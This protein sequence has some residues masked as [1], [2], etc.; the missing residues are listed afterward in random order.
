MAHNS[1]E[2]ITPKVFVSYSWTSDEHVEWVLDLAQR[3]VGNGVDVVIDRWDLKAGQDKFQ[4]MERMVLD[5]TIAKV[6]VVC[7]KG[8]AE[9]ANNRAGGVGTESTII[10][11]NVYN[12]VEQTKFL[13]IIAER[14]EEKNAF[15]PVFLESRIYF[16]LSDPR[17]FSESYEELLRNLFGKPIHVKPPLGQPPAFLREGARASSALTYKRELFQEAIMK[18]KPHVVGLATDF[19]EAFEGELETFRLEERDPDAAFDEQVFQNIKRFL[20]LRD[21]FI[22]FVLFINRY[23]SDARL[24]DELRDFF[25]RCTR[26]LGL[27]RYEQRSEDNYRFLLWE[28]FLYTV[29]GLVKDHR[30]SEAGAL[31]SAPYSDPE[32]QDSGTR[33]MINGYGV[34]AREVRSL[35]EDRQRRLQTRFY[36]PLAEILRERATHP[37]ISFA[38]LRDV[39]YALFLR[40]WLK[41]GDRG[42]LLSWPPRTI[43]YTSDAPTLPLFARAQSK[44]EFAGLKLVLNVQDKDELV[45]RVQA[46]KFP[47]FDSLWDD[48][49]DSHQLFMNL[50]QL[51]TL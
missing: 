30:Y 39:D 37:K 24:W 22:D 51:D 50:D 48:G 12:Q 21:E 46:S 1:T 13:P 15:T 25:A 10:S 43:G 2:Q 11:Q 33:T 45:S 17:H 35:K 5:P 47:Q 26:F 27:S 36:E 8:Y 14:D 6:L 16:D 7:D 19:F 29:T 41:R 23:G 20:P 3:L 42:T 18:A 40:Y 34:F 49:H 4:F 9:K 38:E 32:R 31:L 28:L 44:T